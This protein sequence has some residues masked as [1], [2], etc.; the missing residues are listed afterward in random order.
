MGITVNPRFDYSLVEV[1]GK[2]Y[3]IGSDRLPV[4]AEDIGW[5]DYKVLKQLKGTDFD[6]DD[7]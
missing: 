1:D 3:V 7:L 6:G 5:K 2:K 4:V